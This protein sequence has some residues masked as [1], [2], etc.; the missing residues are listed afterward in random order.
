METIIKEYLTRIRTGKKQEYLNMSVLP[1]SSKLASKANYLTLKEGLQNGY[2]NV[3]EREKAATVSSVDVT[4]RGEHPVILTQGEE[5]EGAM[6]NR[7][8]NTTI[9]I[10]AKS[11]T[12]IPV[13]C[14]ESGRWSYRSSDDNDLIFGVGLL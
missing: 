4:N 6:Q 8:F 5:I 11:R 7:V 13:S 1:I 3:I 2:I 14:T 12:I 10:G 9:L